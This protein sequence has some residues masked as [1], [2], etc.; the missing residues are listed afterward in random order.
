LSG[1][2]S[3]TDFLGPGLTWP[4]GGMVVVGHSGAIFPIWPRLLYYSSSVAAGF[5]YNWPSP[6]TR[7][8]REFLP[9]A[10]AFAQRFL[11][12]AATAAT[13]SAWF[14]LSGRRRGASLYL[15]PTFFGTI[16]GLLESNDSEV[17]VGA[18]RLCWALGLRA[19]S[20]ER[21]LLRVAEMNSSSDCRASRLKA[22]QVWI[23]ERSLRTDVFQGCAQPYS[24]DQ[25]TGR[26]CEIRERA[27]I[28]QM[29]TTRHTTDGGTSTRF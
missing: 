29:T 26:Q 8:Y 24:I 28:R 1:I 25:E 21:R 22:A 6:T 7:L 4:N 20:L 23:G 18:C 17:V 3:A 9:A 11:A 16:G 27:A 13:L 14:G 10:L 12:A 5:L 19:R 15:R 2:V